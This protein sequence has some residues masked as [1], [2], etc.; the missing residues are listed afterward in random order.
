MVDHLLG[1]VEVELDQVKLRVT[2]LREEHLPG[3]G[4]PDLVPGDID[5]RVIGHS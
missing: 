4:D 2:A 3:V 5:D 1:E